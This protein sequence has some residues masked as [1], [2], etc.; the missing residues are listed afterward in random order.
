MTAAP[1]ATSVERDEGVRRAYSADASGL[2][3]VPEGV[4]RPTSASEVAALLAE[5]SAN[6]TA[7]TCAGG[8]TSTTGASISDKG[9]ILSLRGMDRV[10]EL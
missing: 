9:I 10:I 7:V 2:V 8:Q 6:G 4:A 3:M 1:L 5:A